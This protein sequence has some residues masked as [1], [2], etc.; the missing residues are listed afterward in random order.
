MKAKFIVPLLCALP[1]M[2]N[3]AIPYRVE[4]I[5]TPV[6]DVP[7]GLDNESLARM[8]RFYI[9]GMYNMSLWQDYTNEH[10]V[11][12]HGKDAGGFEVM[13]GVRIVDTFRTEINYA[14]NDAKWDEMSFQTDALM[15]NAIIDARIDNLYRPL[16]NQ[17]IVPY[18]G[19]GAGLSW[20]SANDGIEL[21][22]K[23][24]PVMSA[25]A[26]LAFEFNDIF[27]LDLG[28]KYF[29]MFKPESNVMPELNPVAHQLRAGARISF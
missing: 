12:I 27:A 11:S 9:A 14:H 7:S 17:M 25:M 8:R 3:A 24:T 19:L 6:A 21:D 28:Y 18:V 26:G 23:V 10:D 4:Q 22:K 2:A 5:K 16:R 1:M 20:N 13:A 15:V 29:Y